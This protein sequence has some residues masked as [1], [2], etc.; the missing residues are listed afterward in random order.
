MSRSFEGYMAVLIVGDLA[1][2]RH[3][4]EHALGLPYVNG[5]E[6]SAYLKMG[7]DGLL[8]STTWR[9]MICSVLTTSTTSR[10][11]AKMLM[12]TE[13][14]DVDAAYEELKAKGVEF[15]RTPEDRAW[16]LRCAHFKDPDG[17]VWE[18]NQ[19]IAAAD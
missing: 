5:D 8:S 12:V 17:N 10:L 9:Q 7:A 13:V 19:P 3:F 6:R 14:D 15:L 1:A 16:G 18:I 2:S 11:L 4:Y